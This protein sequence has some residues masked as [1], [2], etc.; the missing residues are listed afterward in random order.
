MEITLE[1]TL[2]SSYSMSS[3]GDRPME[4]LSL[5]FTKIEFKAIPYDEKGKAGSPATVNYNLA[6]GTKG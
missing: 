5:N 6:T 2:I 3:G 1:N 4:S